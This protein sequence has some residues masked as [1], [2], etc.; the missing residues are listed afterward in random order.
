MT[1]IADLRQNIQVEET[2]Y[3]AGVSE[4]TLQKVG[5]GINFINNRQ[6]QEKTFQANGLYGRI[7]SFPELF[8][9]GLT[10]L[11]FDAEIINAFFYI[12]TP[13]S[14]G[15]TE[16]DVKWAAAGSSTWTSIFTTTP[17][18]TSSAAAGARVDADGSNPATTGVTAPVLD[19]TEL[20]RDAGDSLR[21]DI[22]TAMTGDPITVGCVIFYR[23]R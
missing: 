21:F 8:A 15:T 3:G 13:G 1:D 23:P 12:R 5:G 6:Y 7:A 22:I 20:N 16:I 9:D 2:R 4:F 10:M 11:N 19:V 14:G 17:K 18:F